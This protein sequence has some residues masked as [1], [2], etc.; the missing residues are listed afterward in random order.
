L[1]IRYRCR[2]ISVLAAAAAAAAA[3]VGIFASGSGEMN[4]SYL[5]YR[6]QQQ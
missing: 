3:V 5:Y 6:Q 4:D 1:E 2:Y